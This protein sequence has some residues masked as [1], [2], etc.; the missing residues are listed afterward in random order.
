MEKEQPRQED[1]P[2]YCI[3]CE[4]KKIGAEV[5]EECTC[6]PITNEDNLK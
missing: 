5:P 1:N 2:N 4:A 6:T 3:A